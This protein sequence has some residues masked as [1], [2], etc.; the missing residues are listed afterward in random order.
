[1]NKKNAAFTLT[2]AERTTLI[3]QVVDTAT[4]AA[5]SPKAVRSGLFFAA[6][7]A[8]LSGID[9]ETFLNAAAADFDNAKRGTQ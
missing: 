3:E 2:D 1:M 9:R 5:A 8:A 6:G 7:V 4:Q